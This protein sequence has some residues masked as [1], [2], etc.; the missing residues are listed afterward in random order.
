MG[1]KSIEIYYDIAEIP[2]IEDRSAFSSEA[3]DFRN[4]A[5]DHIEQALNA[6]DAGEWAGA[7]I[8]AG[9]VNFGFCVED[10]DAAEAIIYQA[11]SGTRF[12]KIREIS[13]HDFSQEDL[14]VE[15]TNTKP[16]GFLGLIYL[17]VFRR[18]PKRFRSN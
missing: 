8:G 18:L 3:L 4:A 9:E 14:A 13:R 15:Q 11:V 5:M 16:L 12:A 2:G 7:E 17:L 6:A 10:F 1:E